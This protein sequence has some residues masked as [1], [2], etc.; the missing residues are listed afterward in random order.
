MNYLNNTLIDNSSDELSMTTTLKICLSMDGVKTVSIATGYWDIPGLALLQKELRFFLEKKDTNLRILIGKDPYI[1]TSQINLPKYKDA[2]YPKDF[3]RTD[4]NELDVIDEYKDAVRLLLDYCT[5]YNDSKIQIRIFSKN[6]NEEKQFLHS[7]CYIFDGRESKI[8][9]GIVGSSNFTKKGLQGNAELNYIEV[10]SQQVLSDTRLPGNKS[11]LLWF[12]DIWEI[13]EPWNRQFMEQILKPAPITIEVEKDK[14]HEIQS[15]QFSPYELYIKFLQIKFGDIVDKNLG[16]QIE[17]YL[18]SKMTTLSYQIEAVKRCI[19]IMHEHGGFMLSDVVGLGKTVVGTLIIRRF[20]TVPEDD[21]RERKVLI[22]TPPA[23]KSAWK[24][25]VAE[26]D[27][28]KEEKI[29]SN[30][31]YVTTGSIGNIIDGDDED[32]SDERDTGDFDI[33][34]EFRNY[35]FILIDE[36]HKFRNSD[37]DMYKKLDNLIYQ[38]TVNT[39]VAPYIGLLSATPQNNSPRDLRNQIYLFERNHNESTLKKAES[40]NLETFFKNVIYEYD[41]LIKVPDDEAE[42]QKAEREKQLKSL[43][44]RIR[45]CVL[46]DILER[47]TRTDVL[48]YYADDMQKQNI[49]F[50]E[51]K[52]PCMLE[53]K[54]D[55]KL[56]RLFSDTMTLIAPPTNV[57]KKCGCDYLEYYRYRAIQYFKD[58]KNRQKYAGRGALDSEKVA[59]QLARIMQMLLVKRLESSFT[60]F[61]SSLRNLLRYTENMINM[62]NNDTIFVCPQIDVN[63]EL[64]VEAKTEKRGHN[65]TFNDCVKDIRNIIKRLTEEGKNEKEQ[66]AEYKREDFDD[67]YIINLKKDFELITQ[68]YARWEDNTSDPKFDEFKKQLQPNLFNPQTNTEGKLVIFSEAIDTVESLS[69]AVKDIGYNP[70]VI[71]ASNR[72]EKEQLIQ[73]NFDANYEG[74]WKNDYQVIITTDVLAEGIN[75][76]RANVI[77]NYDTPW[78]STRLMQRIG[79]VNRIGSK[80]HAVY[81]YNFMPSAQGDA[82]IQL[83]QKAHTKLQSF[84][85]LFGEDSK[86][87]SDDETISHY[88]LHE[89]VNGEE[90]PMEKYVF[91]LKQFKEENPERYTLIEQTE[92]GWEIASHTNGDAYFYV[93][94][95]QSSGLCIKICQDGKAKP[96]FISALDMIEALKIGKSK[97]AA[98]LPNDWKD[99]RETAI[100]AYNQYFIRINKSWVKDK[101]TEAQRVINQI[102]EKYKSSKDLKNLLTIVMS[103]VRKGQ[104]DIIRKMVEV[105]QYINS[106]QQW[107]FALNEEDLLEFLKREI[108]QLLSKVEAKQGKAEILTATCK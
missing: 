12:N 13:S 53:Y 36:S 56:A 92:K 77:L 78:N 69:S 105:G 79:R 75:L 55:Y 16:E 37:T 91:E 24:R 101:K 58:I 71:N 51:I 86:I 81:I 48:K 99:L 96:Q 28:E 25:I 34:L 88:A 18:P 30:I 32:N 70:L 52:G 94:A 8:G 87:F 43:S 44:L 64:D 45:E 80:A 7:K 97:E 47:R 27:K 68:L 33:E 17:S 40:G 35:G 76:H 41:C 23:I 5:E 26:F 49:V 11:H 74:Q 31:R 10:N 57:D 67:D 62:W 29:A 98:L 100:I 9:I 103:V 61:I 66:N 108:G 107:F 39:G 93:K 60:A 106:N 4:I 1:Y 6:E 38:I 72:K 90:S 104:R 21:G 50:P 89:A 85:T 22:I 46:D 19:S 59:N 14:E 54:M 84:H 20:L 15:L 65:V 82:E 63:K 95:P 2:N 83:V 3:I 73:E 102:Y 42:E